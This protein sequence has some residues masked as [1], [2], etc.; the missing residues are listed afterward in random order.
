MNRIILQKAVSPA[1]GRSYLANSADTVAG[2]VLRAADVLDA[3]TPDLLF[4][5]HG[6]GFSGSPWQR[7]SETIDVI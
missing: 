6:L 7:D 5:A 3:R 2:Y 1:L 4:D